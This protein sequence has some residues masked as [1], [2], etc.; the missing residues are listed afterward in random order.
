MIGAI[1]N[2][3]AVLV[4]GVLGLSGVRDLSLNA[5]QRLK[6]AL[7]AGLV[8]VGFSLTWKSLNGSVGQ[9]LRQFLVVMLA[10]IAGNVIG[11]LLRLQKSLN[12]LGQYAKKGLSLSP[13]SAQPNRMSNGFI[14]CS[15]LFCAG[16]IALLGALEEGFS[17]SFKTL[18]LKSVMDGMAAKGLSKMF[19]Y[20]VIFS[21][22]PVAAL[23][24]S[25]TLAARILS[26]YLPNPALLDSINATCGLLIAF[27][28]LIVLELKKVQ[29]G[30]YLPSLI[31]APLITWIWR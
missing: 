16:P 17:S 24:G 26:Q 11:K 27:L 6:I 4:G 22:I 8:L 1:L 14:T 5:Q 2:A 29:I 28:A 21:A 15:V 9:I 31:F 10:L 3:M 12:R 30:D 19:G 7:A 25:V 20:G 18:A 23:E 13:G